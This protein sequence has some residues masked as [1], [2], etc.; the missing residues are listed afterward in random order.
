MASTLQI[1]G[2]CTKRTQYMGMTDTSTVFAAELKGLVL[3]LEMLLDIYA[4]GTPLGKCAIFTDNQAAI[5]AIRNPK[6]PSGEYILVRAICTL[7]RLRS[8]GWEVQFRWIPA[9]VGVP[10]NEA[11]D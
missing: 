2:I 4:T 6:T 10:G 1:N 3:A 9:H 5:Q 7:D 8:H 11:A